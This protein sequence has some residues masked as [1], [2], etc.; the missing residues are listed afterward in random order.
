MGKSWSALENHVTTLCNNEKSVSVHGPH[1]SCVNSEVQ[2]HRRRRKKHY[3]MP[4]KE[5]NMHYQEV[6]PV[7]K[8]NRVNL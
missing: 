4:S 3:S 7:G 6:I 8:D 1:M 5:E 2:L